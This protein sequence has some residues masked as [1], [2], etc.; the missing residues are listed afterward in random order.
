MG[1]GAAAL[2]TCARVPRRLGPSG[3]C[4][5][6]RSE[7]EDGGRGRVRQL[8]SDG[9]GLRSRL[10]VKQPNLRPPQ[11]RGHGLGDLLGVRSRTER[12]GLGHGGPDLGVVGRNGPVHVHNPVDGLEDGPHLIRHA[13]LL[14]VVGPV[15]LCGQGRHHR[16]PRRDLRQLHGSPERP[17]HG[18][19]RRTHPQCDGVTLIRA[20]GLGLQV[21]L[22][23]GNGRS[24]AQ[25]VVSHQTVE[26][27]RRRHPCV[28]LHIAHRRDP[29]W[30]QVPVPG[31]PPPSV[32][33]RFP[34]ACP[35]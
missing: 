8:K 31:P 19:H 22:D 16:G 20:L 5:G 17:G 15:D 4:Q 25:E 7:V 30:R 24:P 14:L 10:V 29:A 21:D 34:P 28:R 27:E 9:D 13:N 1:C 35:R 11:G 33:E 2:S 12:L 23:I 32:P 3:C 18:I 6:N 26:V